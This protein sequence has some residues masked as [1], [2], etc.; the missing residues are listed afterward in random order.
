M[1]SVSP[2][3]GCSPIQQAEQRSLMDHN[4]RRRTRPTSGLDRAEQLAAE[5]EAVSELPHVE[6][7]LQEIQQAGER[8]RSRTLTRTSQDAADVKASIL[9]GSRGLD[10]FHIS[11]R[12]ESLSAATTFEPLEPVKDTDIQGFLKNERDNALLS[13]IEESRRR[14]FLLAE[15]YH[16]ESMLVQW[17]QVKQR[18]LHTLL[19]AGEDALDF[20]QDVEPSFVSEVT[21]PGRSAL[22][23]VEVAYGRQIYIFNEKIVNGHIQPNLGDLCASVAESLDDK[24]VSDMWLMVK[25][26]TDVLLVPAKDT[27]KSRIS[28]EMQMAFVRQALN[29]LENSYKNYTMVTV[30]G[31]LHQAQLGGV[32]GTYQLVCSF[33]NIKLPGPLPG[34]QDGEIEGHPVWAVI[35]YCL[36]C[37]D[38]NAA[39][40]VVNRVQ[41]QLGDFKTWF[42]EY[43]N[44][45]DRRLS[46]TSENKLRLHYRRVLRN[47]AD[48]YKRAVYC[49][50]GKCDISDN[51]GEVADKTEDYLWLKL[52]Q[53]CFDDDGSSSSQDRLTLP[54][55]Q[56]QLL[57]DYGESHFSASQQPFLYFQ[58]LFL[59]AQFEAAVAFLFRAER[60]RSHA[61]HVALVLYE[62]RLLLKSSGQ[63]AQLLSQEHG[64]PPM[65]RRL[66]FILRL[67]SYMDTVYFSL[68]YKENCNEKDTQGENMFMRCVSELVI[69]S[70]E[71]D[72]LLGRLE[73]DGSR[74]PGVI[75][76]FAGDTRAIITKVA[77]EAENKGLFEEAVKLYELAKNPDKVLELMNR[78]LSP[79]IAQVSAPQ[80]NKERLKNTAVAIAERYRSQG[81]SGDKSVDSTFYLLLDL[82]TFF[83]EY[84][85][86]HVDRAYDVMERL[87]LLPLSQDSVEERVAAFRN[88]S[89]EVRHNLSEVLLAT[90]NIL[91]TQHKRLK[92]RQ[93]AHQG[94]PR[95]TQRTETCQARALITFAGMIPYNMAGDTNARLVQME[96][97]MN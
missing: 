22:D 95:G 96:L 70:R 3:T 42:Q 67:H 29:F 55:L 23:S 77:L 73:K 35:Y 69:E 91:F 94:D 50:I 41:H 81:V 87:K 19:G 44:S 78:L 51:H 40:Q 57:E 47:S 32:P 25:Q 45:P 16:R 84:H 83:D 92:G 54:Q 36:R 58:V 31:N 13:A 63:S 49:L 61:V 48:P 68:F 5:T 11:Q 18:V 33:L 17:E 15:E 86:G 74:K 10:I 30:F 21:A 66:N 60:L 76:K 34:M 65:V 64:D 88:F 97:L 90:M 7:N 43:M 80:S 28:V 37:G 62:L 24:N 14:T 59:T 4:G 12:L 56:K 75:D 52:N 2:C 38:L 53:V 71:F 39:M 26:M 79:V 6:R 85:A 27:L 46:P 8:L 93:R 82:T 72:M 9:L 20:S 1:F 89:D